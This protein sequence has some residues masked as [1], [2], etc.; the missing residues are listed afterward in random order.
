[1]VVAIVTDSAADLPPAEADT[2]GIRVVPLTVSFGDQSFRAGVDLS[3]EQFWARMTAPDAPFPTTAAASPGAFQVAFQEA[4]DAGAEAIVYVG[5]AGSLSGTIKSAHIARDLFPGRNIYVI[6]SRSASMAVGVLALLGAE[7]AAAGVSAPD[8]AAEL[9]LRTA[10]TDFYVVLETLDYLVRGG[11]LSGTRAAIGTLLS[12]KPILTIRDGV[13]E[14][15]D[16]VRTRSKARERILELMA[17]RPVER[18]AIL[19]AGDVPDIDQFRLEV[20]ERVPGGIDPAHVTTQLI[21]ASIGPHV[22]PGAY[23]GVLLYRRD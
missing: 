10:D 1:M 13:V 17:T 15:A 21:G 11:R 5:V 16:R 9:E 20:V 7:R 6:D 3:T 4:F 8:I 2:A 18:L 14:Q 22:G 19:H 12:M 23:G